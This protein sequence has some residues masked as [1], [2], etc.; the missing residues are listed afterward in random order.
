MRVCNPKILAL[1]FGAG[2]AI[3]ASSIAASASTVL[4]DSTYNDVTATPSFNNS[5]GGSVTAAGCTNCGNAGVPGLQIQ[6]DFTNATAAGSKASDAGV[7]DNVMSYNPSVLGAISTISASV[8][9]NNLLTGLVSSQFGF[10]QSVLRLLIEQG[11]SYYL[12]VVPVSPGYNCTATDC[13]PGFIHFS[14]SGVT[15]NSFNLID[16]TT[17]TITSSLHPNF[18]SGTMLFGVEAQ[19][20]PG[21]GPGQTVTAIYDPLVITVNQTPLPAALPLFASGLGAL[22]LL[23]WRRKRKAQ[24]AA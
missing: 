8:D 9:K 17:N 19:S 22:G 2:L 10:Y 18:S 12:A 23:G 13:S 24:A 1:T 21:F 11:P 16:L 5:T 6:F 15:A 7:I 14:I 3:A 4:T 20:I